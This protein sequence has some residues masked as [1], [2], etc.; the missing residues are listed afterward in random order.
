M[1]LDLSGAWGLE[2]VL[3]GEGV[4]KQFHTISPDAGSGDVPGDVYTD[5]WRVGRID[6]PH[7]GV[8]GQRAKW[9]MDYEW[10]YFKSFNIPKEME[11]KQIHIKFD[12]V[13][14]EC[15]VW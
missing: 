6:D 7:V 2:G 8:N 15:D 12:G 1:V 4:K 5:L 11:G 9:I 13:D 14:Y 3:P 10:W